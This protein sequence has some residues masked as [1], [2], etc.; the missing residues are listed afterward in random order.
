MGLDM[1]LTRDYHLSTYQPGTLGLS[2]GSDSAVRYS[3]EFS[4]ASQIAA[5][6]GAPLSGE[7]IGTL[8]VQVPVGYWRKANQIH[9][10]FVANIGDGVDE[11]QEMSLT[12]E[13]LTELL[14]VCVEVQRDH[15]L[16]EELL[17]PQAGFF[18]GST[19]TDEWYF[20]DVTDTII[21]LKATLDAATA[22][23]DP[24]PTW[25]YRASW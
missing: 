7:G 4:Q 21:L 6:L 25:T 12:R 20:R 15:S 5:I 18:F 11:C 3:K 9:N 23:G 2:E 17:P 24:W 13:N 1:Y 19:E 22:D 14:G 16:A 10:W 8:S